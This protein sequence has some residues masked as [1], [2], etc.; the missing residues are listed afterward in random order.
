[1]LGSSSSRNFNV[2]YFNVAL[3]GD[4]GPQGPQG[5][6]GEPGTP[7]GPPG[8]QGV[9]GPEG[10]EGD[11]GPPGATGPQGPQGI[12]GEGGASDW[13]DI[14][15]KP[16]TFPPSTHGHA[17]ADVTNLQTSLNAKEP[18]IA[19]GTTAQY[20]RGDKSWQTLPAAP[21]PLYV[22]DTPPAGAP[23]N[24]LWWE[25]DSG[26]LYLRYND[27]VGAAQW[28]Q[29]VAVPALDTSAFVMKSGDVM[30]G[31]LTLPGNPTVALHAAPKQYVDA[32]AVPASRFQ[33]VSLSGTP[34]FVITVPAT[35]VAAKLTGFIATTSG[36]N[37][38]PLLELGFSGVYPAVG[39]YYLSG[40]DNKSSAA[41]IANVYANLATLA[42]MLLAQGNGNVGVHILFN[43]QVLLRRRSTGVSFNSMFL[44]TVYNADSTVTSTYYSNL[45]GST[46][47][48]ALQVTTLRVTTVPA[49]A[50]Q[51]DSFLDVEWL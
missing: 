41:T 7:G 3:K 30:T 48:A 14:A 20:W 46:A 24:S 47:T 35:A 9:P 36:A 33:R 51:S 17:I 16:A 26:V 2:P 38:Y 34:P 39:Q 44:G 22:S 15:N 21:P 8:P 32:N 25:S 12:P 31:P 37:Q 40:F 18:T 50:L 29:A 4:T 28:V 10:P 49:T 19:A 6:Q 45:L 1:M 27:G 13:A 43:G 23:D 42:G 5:E 11:P